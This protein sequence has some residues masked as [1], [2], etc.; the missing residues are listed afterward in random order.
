MRPLIIE[1]PDHVG[2]STFA[3]GVQFTTKA[4]LHHCD[5]ED[6]KRK[7]PRDWLEMLHD[8]RIYDRFHIGQ[9]VYGHVLAL[10]EC[11]DGYNFHRF[12]HNCQQI[13]ARA[14]VVVF[15]CGGDVLK[16]RLEDVSL[17]KQEKFPVSAILEANEL[18]RQMIMEWEVPV[19]TY[20]FD[21][22]ERYPGPEEMD[23]WIS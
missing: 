22:T 2:K 9:F 7:Y 3:K 23:K 6:G 13:L 16:K 1:G 14:T 20:H 15:T 19:C 10:H 11:P 5:S 18:Y 21:V 17:Q 8:W 4:K 12:V